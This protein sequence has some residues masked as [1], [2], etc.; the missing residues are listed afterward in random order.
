MSILPNIDRVARGTEEFW[1]PALVAAVGSAGQAVNQSNANKRAS[2]AEVQSIDD[3]QQYRQ[4]ANDQVKNLTQQIATNSPQQIASQ[5][6]GQFVNT[7]RKNAAGSAQ[8]GATGSAPN[9]TNFGAPVSAM[10]PAAGASS[11]YKS[12]A[13]SA[14]QQTQQ[15]GNTY[16]TEIG[17]IDAA[18][19]QRQNE[20]LAQQTLGTNLNV[21]GAESYTKNF[22]DQLRAQTAGQSNP[23]V[24]LF[25]NMLQKGAS[26]YASNAGGS[27]GSGDAPLSTGWL[28][29]TTP[30][31]G[32]GNM[33]QPFIP[34]T[35][36]QNPWGGP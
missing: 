34:L 24:S 12:D 35:P 32:A 22:V 11:R 9:D 31:T 23:W 27:A 21:L 36:E 4:Q 19:R 33:N 18:V 17:N 30:I 15:Y 7:L 10:P 6:T 26:A 28:A 5:E 20:G 25:S 2:N 14:Q 13:A 8:P 16:A 1:V 3:Q 29:G